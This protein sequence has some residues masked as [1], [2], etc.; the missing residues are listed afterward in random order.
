[1]IRREC[2]SPTEQLQV[3][4]YPFRRMF[5]DWRILKTLIDWLA[6]IV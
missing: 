2:N 5:A 4:F 6:A 3:D 1:V